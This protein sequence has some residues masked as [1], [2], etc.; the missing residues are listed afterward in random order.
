[1]ST[2]TSTY[3]EKPSLFLVSLVA[4][5]LAKPRRTR[6]CSAK[7]ALYLIIKNVAVR[8]AAV[9]VNEV[10][11]SSSNRRTRN[12]AFAAMWITFG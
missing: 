1:M 3:S 5:E 11:N 9:E 12:E 7:E 8:G 10:A 2:V 4:C 6:N